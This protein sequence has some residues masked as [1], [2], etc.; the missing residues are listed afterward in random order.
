M[1]ASTRGD[2]RVLWETGHPPGHPDVLHGHRARRPGQRSPAFPGASSDLLDTGTTAKLPTTPPAA[3]AAPTTGSRCASAL[4][5]MV[6]DEAELVVA[7][8]WAAGAPTWKPERSRPAINVRVVHDNLTN[9]R[10]PVLV[11]HYRHDV[12][13]AAEAYLDRRLDR[14]LSE[15]L[16]MEL[17]PGPINTGVVVLNEPT[18]GD[19]SI[20]PGAIVAGLGNVGE[21]TPGSLTSTLAH[22]LT[23]YGAECVG[24]ERRRQQREGAVLDSAAPCRRR[25]RRFWS[26]PA[27]AACRLPT[28][29]ARCCAPCCRRTSACAAAPKPRQ[30]RRRSHALIAQ[31]DQRGHPR[32][33]RGPRHRGAARAPRAVAGAGVRR[34]SSSRNCW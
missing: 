12:I 2:G 15:L 21:L 13:V 34:L 29:C 27:K 26:D 32:A 9:A 8:R 5:A 30:R 3:R 11:S 7:K 4:P 28:A 23:L 18:P 24:R 10:S 17:Y 1:L 33:L 20:H 25:S 6:P 14:R 16:R 22:A 19:L 31:I